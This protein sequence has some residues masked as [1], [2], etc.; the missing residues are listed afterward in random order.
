MVA[1][2]ALLRLIER[3]SLLTYFAWMNKGAFASHPSGKPE[4]QL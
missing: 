4:P 2:L 3:A 1:L